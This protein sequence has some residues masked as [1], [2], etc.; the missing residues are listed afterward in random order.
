MKLPPATIITQ[1]TTEALTLAEVK[2]HLNLSSSDTAHD[3]ELMLH[4]AGAREQWET[5]TSHLVVPR[6]LELK[7]PNFY[8]G[9]VFHERPVTSITY[10][11]YYDGDNTEQ[12]LSTSIYA[13]NVASRKIELKYNQTFPTTLDR[14]DAVTIRYVCGESYCNPMA[15]RCM[16]Q[17]VGY[18]FEQ[19]GD[20]DR[21]YDLR[22]YEMLRG[23]FM[24]TSYP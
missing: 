5:D 24:R 17:L 11:K 22:S 15:K 4:I 19:R 2:S 20:N 14:W 3:A 8:E 9:I 21:A 13:L 16:L 18:F 6:T 12:T 23:R 7:L 10:I 1:P